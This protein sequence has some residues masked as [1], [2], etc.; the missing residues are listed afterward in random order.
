MILAAVTIAVGGGLS[1]VA[2]APAEAATGCGYWRS[3]TQRPPSIRVLLG[4]GRIVWVDFRRYVERVTSSEWGSTP[5]ELRKAGALAVMQYAWR[6][7]TRW[8]G[9]SYRGT[10]F[11]VYS[12][13]R[14]Q[15]YRHTK[16]ASF[17]AVGATGWA[18]QH[19]LRNARSGT[20]LFTS[21]R[22]G[23]RKRCASDAGRRLYARSATR[24]ANA[25]WSAERI[26]EA[27]Y[28]DSRAVLR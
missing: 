17:E 14:D 19:T 13:T 12:S 16:T 5:A 28:S 23:D 27:Y 1:P 15:I 3:E 26:L 21:Y 11:H 10:C 25:G 22:A 9:Q 6:H 2:S 4:D 8:S 7:V 20:L 24:C 18:F